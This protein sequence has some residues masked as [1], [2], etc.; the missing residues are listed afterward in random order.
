MSKLFAMCSLLT[1]TSFSG[2]VNQISSFNQQT[3]QRKN[4]IQFLLI[5]ELI[6]LDM[7]INDEQGKAKQHTHKTA[8][9]VS[10]GDGFRPTCTIEHC[11][12]CAAIQTAPRGLKTSH[13]GWRRDEVRRTG[14]HWDGPL[15]K[16]QLIIW[17]WHFH[18]CHSLC[19]VK[20]KINTSGSNLKQRLS[21]SSEGNENNLQKY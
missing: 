19:C 5:N 13:V 1:L 8:E 16:K 4:K 17:V 10:I 15:I 7:S 14:M 2:S 21:G 6:S 9:S 18:P 20:N 11:A 3:Q 12:E